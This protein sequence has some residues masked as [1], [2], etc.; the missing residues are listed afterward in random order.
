MQINTSPNAAIS[1][2]LSFEFKVKHGYCDPDYS[3]D[4]F[5]R[6]PPEQSGLAADLVDHLLKPG[7]ERAMRADDEQN[8]REAMSSV[9]ANALAANR[10]GRPCAYHRGVSGYDRRKRSIP[11]GLSRTPVLAIVDRLKEAGYLAGTISPS[12]PNCGELSTYQA[13]DMLLDA[14]RNAGLTPESAALASVDRPLIIL[15]DEKKNLVALDSSSSTIIDM[16]NDIRE[17]NEYM[18]SQVVEIPGPDGTISEI[19]HKSLYRVFNN[20]SL[21]SGGRYFGGAWQRIGNNRHLIRINGEATIELDFGGFMPRALYHLA[22]MEYLDDPYHIDELRLAAEKAGVTW[23]KARDG[24]KVFFMKLLNS[25]SRRG[26]LWVYKS[27]KAEPI[28]IPLPPEFTPGKVMKM[29]EDK[30]TAISDSFLKKRCFELM[31]KESQ[32]TSIVLKSGIDANIPILPI[33]DSY[34]TPEK[35]REFLYSVMSSAYR[36]VFGYD[37]LIR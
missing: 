9:L 15:K 26:L 23:G 17:Y 18:R 34:I 14:I 27:G 21:E 13:T 30:H 1:R 33:H 6:L 11:N 16:E 4:P 29:L 36:K 8:Y 22:G 28:S 12:N 35:H 37:P 19:L 5:L 2:L 25:S 32:I 20:N 3:F 24:L 31:N 7:R 10:Q